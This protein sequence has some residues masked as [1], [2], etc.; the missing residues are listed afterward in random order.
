MPV[1]GQLSGNVGGGADQVFP[2]FLSPFGAPAFASWA[3]LSPLGD[4]PPSRS[5]HRTTANVAGIQRDCHVPH[6]RDTTGVGAPYIPR[7]GGVPW[8][9]LGP[10]TSACRIPAACPTTPLTHHICEAHHHETSSGVHTCSPPGSGGALLRRRPLRTVRA[11]RRGTRL[12]QA[13][14]N[15]G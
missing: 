8:P 9:R 1:S 4:P 11:A 14:R 15:L 12:K 6:E 3:I 2:V 7:H 13:I 10:S 5:A